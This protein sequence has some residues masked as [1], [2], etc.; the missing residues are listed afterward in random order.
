M[1]LVI[2]SIVRTF[3]GYY[4]SEK[5]LLLFTVAERERDKQ[6]NVGLY[7]E[8]ESIAWDV[9]SPICGF[10]VHSTYTKLCSVYRQEAGTE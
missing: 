7:F 3:N 9:D 4:F 10:K 8:L 5:Y 1:F 6:C 2:F